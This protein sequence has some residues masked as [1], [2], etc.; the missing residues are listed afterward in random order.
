MCIRDRR[1]VHG[2][3]SREHAGIKHLDD[4]S[5]C[6]FDEKSRYGTSL[7]LRSDIQLKKG[8]RVVLQAGRTVIIATVRGRDEALTH[9]SQCPNLKQGSLFPSMKE[10]IDSTCSDIYPCTLPIILDFISSSKQVQT[11]LCI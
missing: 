1:R 9:S 2:T 4:G 6:L 7:A 10:L 11:S 5:F 3:I 8:E